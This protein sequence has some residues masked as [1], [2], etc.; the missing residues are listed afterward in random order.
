M[1]KFNKVLN[2]I[3]ILLLVL[4]CVAF[5]IFYLVDKT[6]ATDF[7]N[8]LI[9][10]LNRPLPI[11]GVT[12]F[13]VLVFVWKLI[14]TTNYGKKKIAIYDE[15]LK[16]IEEQEKLLNEEKDYLLTSLENENKALRE[17]LAE[18]CSLSTNKKIKN[19]GKELEKYGKETTNCE[20]TKE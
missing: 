10:I 19:Y 14:I 7:I 4:L 6:K 8:W 13:A 16:E 11:V 18:V 17:Q 5:C 9:D 1:K 2:I 3:L 15:K 20:T 12:T